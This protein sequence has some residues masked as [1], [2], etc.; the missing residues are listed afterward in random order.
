M[1]DYVRRMLAL[2]ALLL[3]A[4]VSLVQDSQPKACVA[5]GPAST[6]DDRHAA[7]ELGHY[8][9][10]ATGASLPVCNS[11][12]QK[13]KEQARILVGLSAC[14]P[15]I[16]RHISKLRP[17]S[18]YVR[19]SADGIAMLAGNGPRGTSFAVYS[20][21]E[22]AVGIR[23]LWPGELGE[24]VPR[25][26]SLQ[27]QPLSLEQQPA[28][29]LRRVGNFNDSGTR[30]P[31]QS[32]D[33]WAAYQH[34]LG[35]VYDEEALAQ[36]RLWALRNR[37][38]GPATHGGHAFGA[39]VPP[40]KH[41]PA[42][43]EYFAL[44]N[45]KRLWDNYDGKHG[46]QLCTSNPDVVRLVTEY[47]IRT[48]DEHPEYEMISISPNDG[49]GFCECERCRSLDTG[50]YETQN[51]DPEAGGGRTRVITDRIM[52]FAN[53]VTEGVVR[54]HP[55]KKLSILAYGAY[56]QPPAR[57]RIHPSLN[58]QYHLRANMHW[59]PEA[60]RKEFEAIAGWAKAATNL[61]VTEFL[62][63]GALADMPRLFP[64]PMAVSIR[65]IQESNYQHYGTQAGEGFATNGLNYYVL[66]K[67]LW[68]PSLDH[69]EVIRDYVEKGFGKA[70][71]AMM[72]YYAGLMDRWKQNKSRGLTLDD[73]RLKT[74]ESLA[75]LYPSEFRKARRA[76]TDE[77]LGRATGDDRK[78][79]EFVA[80]GLRYLE[81]TLDAV[82]K[83]LPLLKAGWQLGPKDITAPKDPDMR[84]FQGAL[85][86][87]EQREKFIAAQKNTLVLSYRWTR[88]NDYLRTF[89]P[90][91]RMRDWAQ[92]QDRQLRQRVRSALMVPDPRPPLAP[93]LHS[94][95]EP[96]PGIVAERVTY[97]TQFGM[98]IP[99][100][101][102][103]PKERK[104]K[105]PAIIV[106]N[107]HG[108]DKYSWYSFY[109]GILYARAGAVVLTFDPTGE[110]ERNK[111]RESGTR[112]HD[113]LE[114]VDAPY[115]AELARRQGGLIITDVMQAVSYLL[116]RP[117][118]DSA[119]IGAVGYSM[120]SFIVAL[121]GAVDTRLHACVIA[122]GGG[123]QIPTGE[124]KPGSKP[125]CIQGLPYR[126]L[127]FLGDPPAVLY[128]LHA[129]RGP[130]LV[131]NGELDW[132]GK[133]RAR[134]DARWFE[135]LRRRTIEWRGRE[136]GVFDIGAFQA[137]AI[138]R[139]YFVTK[140]VVLWLH[141]QLKFP[142]WTEADIRA[143]PETYVREWAS[144]QNV[145]IDK[146]Y[147]TEGLEAGTRAAGTGIPGLARDQLSVFTREE[148][149]RQKDR[150]VLG[151]WVTQAKRLIRN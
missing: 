10:K 27:V 106:V 85:G 116:Q 49:G 3:V 59:D 21:L 13:P 28:F 129:S 69:R 61:G 104:G 148:W 97:G 88:Y 117:E 47:C 142:N 91:W 75:A 55:G 100:I 107:G 120:G 6:A 146:S 24:I 26:K 144:R 150:L 122:A 51:L 65:R 89:N 8:I 70:A 20:F 73:C 57:V 52:T 90:L 5:L 115:H 64:E 16:G 110:G 2:A 62:I 36:T 133:P 103:L 31:K 112:A 12:R 137:G 32:L 60:A 33:P 136:E 128:S 40:S 38:G 76:D 151:S 135:A 114:P 77:A 53:Q 87:W 17:D 84:L 72:R 93:E 95:F 125:S 101:V 19:V 58:I 96:A 130:T 1:I 18:V 68:D 113:R 118:V 127:A 23:W 81:L 74:Y 108:G 80:Q 41:G 22:K 147:T 123:L 83:S 67:L 4:P 25:A 30:E 44:V 141:R 109:S 99:A 43:P 132:N 140:D 121:T 42:H 7:G 149:D 56:R 11:A 37:F 124:F 131:V 102:Y 48:F 54:R 126:A 139:P 14:P 92:E 50:S 134:Q 45:G 39:M 94:R 82:E 35:I 15:D 34:K 98:R 143:M 119:R 29:T 9:R 66:G 105:V 145:A 111:D 86:A 46:A 138:H 78:R 71:P 63:Q 79:V